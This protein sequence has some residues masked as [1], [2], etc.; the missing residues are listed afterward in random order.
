MWFQL[1]DVPC[2][3]ANEVSACVTRKFGTQ[4]GKGGP[5][6]WSSGSPDLFLINFYVH[7]AVKYIMHVMPITSDMK[8]VSRISFATGY[9]REK[10]AIFHNIRLPMHRRCRSCIAA[11]RWSFEHLLS[12]SIDRCRN[13]CF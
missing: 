4:V 11:K 6:S 9:I 2:Y 10:P 13:K 8:L 12:H 1:D 3:Y 5:I 7:G